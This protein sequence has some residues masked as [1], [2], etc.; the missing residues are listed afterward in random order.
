MADDDLFAVLGDPQGV[1]A[2]VGDDREV[3]GCVPDSFERG[4]RRG[5]QVVPDAEGADA[6]L[7]GQHQGQLGP[8]DA[9]GRQ[10]GD[11]DARGRGRPAQ[12]VVEVLGCQAQQ[13]CVPVRGYAEQAR[14]GDAQPGDGGGGGSVVCLRDH[15]G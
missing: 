4:G 14:R 8:G 13:V 5:D 3:G 7:L 2:G 11:A 6:R 1:G 15:R 10:F 9:D 12:V